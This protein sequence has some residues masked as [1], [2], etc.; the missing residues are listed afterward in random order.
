MFY[1]VYILYSLKDKK[2]YTGKTQDIYERLR[3]HSEGLV[4]ST[5]N[6]RP[7]VLINCEVYKTHREA[8]LRER[9]LKFPSAGRFK[10]ALREK[11]GINPS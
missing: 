9:E 2:F 11:L 1:Y 4:L 3:R 6:R 8:F 5:K 10:K 7:L